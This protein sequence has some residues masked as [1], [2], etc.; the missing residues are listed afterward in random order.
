[1]RLGTPVGIAGATLAAVLLTAGCAGRTELRRGAEE[2]GPT[3][4]GT[5]TAPSSAQRPVPDTAG[6]AT[7]VPAPVPASLLGDREVAAE[8]VRAVRNGPQ[9]PAVEGRLPECVLGA[10]RAAGPA[11]GKLASA[12][13]YPTGSVLAHYVAGYPVPVLDRMLR[14]VA[15]CGRPLPTPAAAERAQVRWCEPNLGGTVSC[16][17]LLSAD[18]Q[19]SLVT[20]RSAQRQ[21]AA[22]AVRRLAPVAAAKLSVGPTP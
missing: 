7:P 13:R 6:R 22:E 2:P 18:R 15:G 12:W 4:P 20:V 16:S 17:V 8:G 21:R 14:E 1:M 9:V 10:L 3:Q 19:L 5:A 11:G